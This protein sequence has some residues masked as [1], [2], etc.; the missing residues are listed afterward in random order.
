MTL[1]TRLAI[2]MIALVA[3]AVA[4]VGWLSYRS[5]EQA[6]VPRMLDRIETHS[7][8]MA[9]DLD[10]HVRSAPGDVTTFTGLAAVGGM[11]RA[12]LNG[13]IDPIDGTTE[14]V[15]RERLEG[16]LVAQMAIKPAYALRFIG[17]ADGHRE[18]VRIDRSGPNGKVRAVTEA[19]LKQVGSTYFDETIKLAPDGIYV[20][21]VGLNEENGVIDSPPVPTMIIAKPV[22]APDGKPY[23]IVV[24]NI[25]M[26]PPLDRIRASGRAGEH[27]YVVD[28]SGNYLV[29]PDRAKEFG[30]QQGK[31]TNWSSD[32]PYL[33]AARGAASSLSTMITDQ[34][35]QLNGV[36]LTPAQLAGRQWAAVIEVVPYG[37][38]MGPAIAIR[39]TTV[40]IG[41]LAVLAAAV[42]AVLIARSLTRPITRLTAAVEGVANRGTAAIPVDASGETGVLARAFVRVMDEGNAKTVALEHEIAEHR[43]TEQVL[44]QQSEELRR[45]FETSQDLIMVMDSRGSIV[46]ISPS[47]ATI[48]G[49]SAK[50]MI[51]R[52]GVDF[53]HPDHL[54]NS[55]EEMRALRRGEH[56]TLADTRC[57]HADGSEVWLS[58]LGTWSEP[59]QRYFFVGRDMTESRRVQQ[60]VRDSAQMARGI[61]DGALDAFVQI[62]QSGVIRDWNTQAEKMFGWTHQEAIGRNVFEIMGRPDGPVKSALAGFLKAGSGEVLQPRREVQ[63]RRRDG[64]EFT[65]E[66]SITALKTRDGFVFNGFVRDLTDQLA[67]EERIKQAEKMEAVGQLT[68]G[69]A[70]DFNNILTV[71]TGTI[72]ILGDAVKEQPQLLAI[73]RMIDEA[74]SRGADL[75]QHLLAF[76]RKQPLEPRDID[77]NALVVDTTKLLRRTLGEQVEIQSVFEDE[78][79]LALVD[80]NRLANALLNL[81]LNARD[82]MPH[83]G[84]LVIETASVVLDEGYA[85]LHGDVK[86]GRYAMIAVSDTGSGIPADML[87][88]V[89]DPFF[90]SKGPG[91][92]TGLGLSMVY[93]FIKQSAGHIKIYSEQ[94]HGTTIKMYLPPASGATLA[95]DDAVTAQLAGGNETILVV[96]DDKLVR[97]YVL[98]QLHSLGYVTREA[99]NA[100]EA[101]SIVKAGQPFDLLF[102]DVI[103]P[104]LNGRQLADE[105]SKIRPDLKV[106]FTS[107][108]TE[109]AIIHHGRLDEG[110]LLLPKPY[111]KSEMAAMIR[112]ALGE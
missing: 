107:G 39:N 101:L 71:I 85:G 86:P 110:V 112:K 37:V 62:S 98:T 74:A 9:A 43:R 105:L 100:A 65:A 8:F 76:A 77:I 14:A 12:R 55:R 73:T 56:P 95:A 63:I 41:L 7:R 33:A 83:G 66:L 21:P 20:S 25:D 61:I 104:G 57:V 78:A 45:I 27:V 13:G 31:P 99:G 84:K 1:T 38:F 17:I 80:P 4:A 81:A 64:T 82:A 10:A 18:I 47:C 28:S 30:A 40:L 26:R 108:Y 2:A 102:T 19:E 69:I 59:A 109:N 72:E 48:L 36:A 23:G 106:L 68:G 92:G 53:I 29:N 97:D 24:V 5:L 52:T 90:T 79:C 103:M 3:I 49:Y 44:R 58:W 35:G 54:D 16:R 91:K 50:D 6:V 93:G 42:L 22:L 51:G 88:K 67:A 60:A 15:W 11:M 89:F 70:H 32:L 34:A 46:Q 94:G 111:R 75:T 87:D 96:E